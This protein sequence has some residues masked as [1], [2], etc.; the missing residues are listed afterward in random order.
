MSYRTR[1]KEQRTH[2]NR[3]HTRRVLGPKFAP[4]QKNRAVIKLKNMIMPYSLIKIRAKA[5]PPYSMLNP[6]TI[7]D[8][9]SAISKGVRLVS[10]MHKRSHASSSGGKSSPTHA[11]DWISFTLLAEYAFTI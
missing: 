3:A 11:P 2:T 1:G 7:S 9:P 4:P 10:A 8:S 6:D 5:P